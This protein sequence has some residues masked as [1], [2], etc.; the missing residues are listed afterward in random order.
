MPESL[1]SESARNFRPDLAREF[2]YLLGQMPR[3]DRE[4][5]QGHLIE[6]EE[7]SSRIVEAEQELF[8]A[9]ARNRLPGEWR[10]AFEERLLGTPEGRAKLALARGL[11]RHDKPARGFRRLWWIF[12]GL[13]ATAALI[14]VFFTTCGAG[15]PCDATPPPATAS[16]AQPATQTLELAAITRGQAD[17]PRLT[18]NPNAARLE[19]SVKE[20]ADAFELSLVIAQRSIA[21]GPAGTSL[22]VDST[23]IEPGIYLLTAFRDGAASNYYEFEVV[24]P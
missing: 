13:A 14:V 22:R 1:G 21:K 23:L 19:L 15:R 8:D 3:V 7:T 2:E 10:T 5:F 16:S 20:P 18:L 4:T 17:R 24:R 6:N 9:Y 12:G 11:A